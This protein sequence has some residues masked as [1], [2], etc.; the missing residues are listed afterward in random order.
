MSSRHFLDKNYF[1]GHT[2]LD[3]LAVMEGLSFVYEACALVFL[4]G[5]KMTI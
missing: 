5:N 4:L 2:R 3:I 1:L